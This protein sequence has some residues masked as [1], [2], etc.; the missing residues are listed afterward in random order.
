VDRKKLDRMTI[1]V[2]LDL[3]AAGDKNLDRNGLVKRITE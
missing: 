2:E 3:D 1:K